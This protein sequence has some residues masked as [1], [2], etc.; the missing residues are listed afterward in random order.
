M[1]NK[2]TVDNFS[3]LNVHSQ[4]Y[5]TLTDSRMPSGRYADEVFNQHSASVR[6]LLRGGRGAVRR[7]PSLCVRGLADPAARRYR[8][9]LQGILDHFDSADFMHPG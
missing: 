6:L 4:Q 3:W 5:A 2:M 9:D 8:L 1:V 7:R